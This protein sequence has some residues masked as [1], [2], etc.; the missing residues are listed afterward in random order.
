VRIERADRIGFDRRPDP[1]PDRC[2]D[3]VEDAAIAH[4]SGQDTQRQFRGRFPFDDIGGGRL[5]RV[6]K[7]QEIALAKQLDAA[8]ARWGFV[9]EVG[10]ARI[11]FEFG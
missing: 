1:R 7:Q 6:L 5:V 10:H 9:V 3:G 4:R 11:E 2:H 8:G